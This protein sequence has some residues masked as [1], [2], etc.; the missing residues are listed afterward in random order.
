[1]KSSH[2]YTFSCSLNNIGSIPDFNIF[3]FQHFPLALMSDIH[4]IHSGL[5]SGS[6]LGFLV[7]VTTIHISSLLV[8]YVIDTLLLDECQYFLSPEERKSTL[9]IYSLAHYIMNTSEHKAPVVDKE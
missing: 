4:V 9:A 3:V 7:I 6:M 2:R 1:M 8:Y 5:V